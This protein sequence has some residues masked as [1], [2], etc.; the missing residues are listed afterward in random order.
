MTCFAEFCRLGLFSWAYKLVLF[1]W[2]SK[3]FSLKYFVIAPSK[4]LFI[5]SGELYGRGFS[6]CLQCGLYFIGANLVVFFI[7]LLICHL[8]QRFTIQ[9]CAKLFF[10]IFLIIPI[11]LILYIL[12]L[13]V[14]FKETQIFFMPGIHRK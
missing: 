3:T 7:G 12:L 4:V 9:L 13:H 8:S 5:I 1:A 11:Y 6:D 14:F 10:F 2:N